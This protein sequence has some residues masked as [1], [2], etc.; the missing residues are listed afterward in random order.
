M[1]RR[2]A[3]ATSSSSAAARTTR[4]SS[5]SAS[6]TSPW[7]RARAPP[8]RSTRG[9]ADR[10]WRWPGG[11]RRWR[12]AMSWRRRY[13]SPSFRCPSASS[14][15]E[16]HGASPRTRWRRRRCRARPRTAPCAGSTR[17]RASDRPRR[18]SRARRWRRAACC[19][20]TSTR[21]SCGQAAA[22]PGASVH[23][24]GASVRSASAS[25]ASVPAPRPSRRPASRSGGV[26]LE[27][28]LERRG[29][30]LAAAARE[31]P[32]RDD[33]LARLAR[34][35][36]CPAPSDE[37]SA[38]RCAAASSYCGCAIDAAGR[39]ARCARAPPRSAFLYF[40][41]LGLRASSPR[42]ARPAPPA[43]CR[44]RGRPRRASRRR[45][46]CRGRCTLMRAQVCEAFFLSP[47]WQ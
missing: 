5:R 27:A 35:A 26:A 38:P 9:R 15:T 16:L 34:E 24:D 46:P 21:S 39:G 47:S 13:I 3:R 44:A 18:A 22:S 17:A 6:S 14:G 11:T 23:H 40:D 32:Q 19:S 29:A 28:A 12:A 20:S 42:A 31:P 33:V 1:L 4:R 7:P 43:A 10:S 2:A 25:D 36:S 41:V 8:A 45:A 37:R 30:L